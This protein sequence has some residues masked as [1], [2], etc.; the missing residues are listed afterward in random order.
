MA[1]NKR[2]SILDSDPMAMEVVQENIQEQ[3][4]SSILDVD[5]MSF[6][7]SPG[8]VPSYDIKVSPQ[9]QQHYSDWDRVKGLGEALI[10]M[11]T[12]A[13]LAIVA[14][15]AA[16]N[17]AVLNKAGLSDV[18]PA[19]AVNAVQSLAY[20]PKSEPG[21][22]MYETL[23]YIPR[24]IS[25]FGHYIG[26]ATFESYQQE[27]QRPPP[28]GPTAP[29]EQAFKQAAFSPAFWGAATEA[30][31]AV[32]SPAVLGKTAGLG[33]R[34][35]RRVVREIK[36]TV[37]APMSLLSK[38]KREA[39][40]KQN[41]GGILRKDAGSPE[42]I[43][44][45]INQV[46]AAKESISTK[47]TPY[48]PTLGAV[49][50]DPLLL[51]RQ[52]QLAS[53]SAENFAQAV[54]RKQQNLIA[55]NTYAKETFGGYADTVN[56]IYKNA[57]NDL[58]K[59]LGALEK[60]KDALIF[61]RRRMADKLVKASPETI[62]KELRKL[63]QK[64]YE[65]ATGIGET[66][67]A[68]VEDVKVKTNTFFEDADALFKQQILIPEEV[69]SSLRYILEQH[70]MF[71]KAQV[72]ASPV[73]LNPKTG[74]PFFTKKTPAGDIVVSFDYLRAIERMLG[75]ELSAERGSFKPVYKKVKL[76]R[77]LRDSLSKTM[78][79]LEKHKEPE[80]VRA[81]REAK[82]FWREGVINRFRKGAARDV[83]ER[84]TFGEYRVVDEKI[85]EQFFSPAT[86]S[87][88]GVKGIQDFIKLYGSNSE[89]WAQL[90]LG[91]MTKFAEFTD[92]TK[93]GVINEQKATTFLYKYD[94]ILEY[95][96]NIKK[97]LQTTA[98]Q[99]EAL[100]FTQKIKEGRKTKI[101]HTELADLV[102]GDIDKLISSAVENPKQMIMLRSQAK[103]NKYA[104]TGL[105]KNIGDHL[106]EKFATTT[107]YG[108]EVKAAKMH[109]YLVK[110]QRSLKIGMAPG[111]YKNLELITKEF[112]R[113]QKVKL[114]AT[115]KGDFQSMLD[116]VPGVRPQAMLQQWIATS[117][118]RQ[119]PRQAVA[120][121]TSMFIIKLGR[122]KTLALESLAY[123]NPEVAA[124]LVD[125]VKIKNQTE[126][127]AFL[128]KKIVKIL[129]KFGLTG[130]AAG[131]VKQEFV[132]SDE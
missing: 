15:G 2:S 131:T 98:K 68:L 57:K 101:E 52:R 39:V 58:G 56:I 30:V 31:T 81:Y 89:A 108:L 9:E 12:E 125:L 49:T 7:A 74:M 118:Q 6:V 79:A 121:L 82:D 124:T 35:A 85:I 88:K 103:H 50:Q 21:K 70:K 99:N 77:D 87:A 105:S 33:V 37:K 41:I 102:K 67:Y 120:S 100:A 8:D 60:K 94:H 55:L 45:Q 36:D 18:S 23:S 4:T 54:R 40:I 34:S 111:H 19:A 10:S 24:K 59:A 27:Q 126:V 26:E 20:S 86:T 93:T 127:P 48:E 80:V 106:L 29:L 90:R 62:G 91:V 107:P 130:V 73:I 119:G 25:E 75:G 65:I 95:I 112:A 97:E 53:E 1:I 5:P 32:A 76:L 64:E 113:E 61:E 116:V 110:H 47:E 63:A 92:A 71:K 28:T 78:D 22:S 122:Q 109:E 115:V 114:P 38:K 43:R 17:A 84:T 132:S 66:K 42:Y 128:Q 69:P 72:G 83:K 51:Q 13:G 117:Q 96:P 104:L 129:Y 14:G 123:Y 16:L 11:G 3:P 46:K 44:E